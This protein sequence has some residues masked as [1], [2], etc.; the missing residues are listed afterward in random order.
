[1]QFGLLREK[2]GRGGIPIA[3]LS[4]KMLVSVWIISKFRRKMLIPIDLRLKRV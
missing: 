2:P 1:M 4:A 3:R